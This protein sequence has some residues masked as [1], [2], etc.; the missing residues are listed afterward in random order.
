MISEY[1]QRS[2]GPLLRP[3]EIEGFARD[4]D[5]TRAAVERLETRIRRME[6]SK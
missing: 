2:Q 1:L 6:E 5:D 3:E 4:V